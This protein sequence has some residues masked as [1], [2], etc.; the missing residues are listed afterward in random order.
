MTD[1]LT[2][3]KR[4]EVMSRI[5][6]KDTKPEFL[7]RE[8]LFGMGYRYRLHAAKLPGRPDMVFP[9]R[10][11]AIFVHGCFWHGHRGC[12]N[13]RIPKSRVEFWQE[14]ISGNKKRDARDHRR[15]GRLGWRSIVIWECETQKD[16]WVGKVILFLEEP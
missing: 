11:K 9:S 15:L 12:S 2:P 4:S 14:K 1:T 13:A 5:R 7:V 3:E 16:G 10:K 6:G 8:K